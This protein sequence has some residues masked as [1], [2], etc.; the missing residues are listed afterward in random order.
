MTQ[1]WRLDGHELSNLIKLKKVSAVEVV[2]A[3]LGRLAEVNSKLNAVVQEMPE[4]AIAEA[5]KIDKKINAGENPGV[6]C[7]VP[8]TIKVVADQKGHATTNGLKLHKDLVAQTDSPIVSNVRKAGGIII[9]RTN[10]PAFSLRWFTNNDLHGQTL[11]PH[12]NLITPGGSSGG[13]SSAVASGMCPIAHGTDI[14]GSIRYPAYAC[15]LHGLRPT[16]GRIPAYNASWPERHIGAQLMAVGGPLA[17]SMKDIEISFEAMSASDSRDP[18]YVP[19]P[20]SGPTFEKRVAFCTNPDDMPVC[21]EVEKEIRNSADKLAQCGWEV[22]EVDCPPMKD[23]ADINAKL[24]MAETRYAASALIEKEGEPNSKFVFEQM[25]KRSPEIDIGGLLEA[26]Q[27]RST[28]LRE[29]QLFL[30]KYPVLI[31]PVSGQLPF[32]QQLDVKSEDDFENIMKAQL[33][34]LAIPALGIP[35][36][37]VFT[38]FAGMTPVGVQLISGRYREDIIIAAGMDLEKSGISPLCVDPSW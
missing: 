22:E 31:T 13:A 10:T 36:L 35:A 7:G 27:K 21:E 23:V 24:W 38:G 32:P 6:L 5:K 28:F 4:E 2:E 30:S 9:G 1:L 16:L 18:W 12:N 14:G 25:T 29:W 20:I 17:R 37:S 11:N 3:H 26:L 34:Q 19:A 33:T 8:I 15:G